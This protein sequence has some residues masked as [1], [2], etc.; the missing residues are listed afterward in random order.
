MTADTNP[1]AT[2]TLLIRNGKQM[3]A[4]FALAEGDKKVIGRDNSCQVQ[5]LDKGISRN[6]SLVEWKGDHF[7]LVDLGSTNG[8]FVNNK[9]IISRKLVDGDI[10]KIGQTELK[11]KELQPE[12]PAASA[13]FV[14]D[15]FV[16]KSP[17]TI[18]ERVDVNQSLA[19]SSR[20][21]HKQDGHEKEGEGDMAA[22]YLSTI[23][24]VSNLTN[25]EQDQAKL[26]AAIMDKIMEVFKPDRAFIVVPEGEDFRVLVQRDLQGGETKLSRT[27]LKKTIHEGVSVL[28]ANAMLDDRFSGNMSIVAQ[29][30]QSVISVPLESSKEVLGAIYID[31]V[32]LSNRFNKAHLDLLTAI[33][34]QAGVAA[35]RAILFKDYMEKE[36]MQ[37]ALDIARKIQT[38]LLPSGAPEN[39]EYDLVGWNVTC[40]ETGGDYYDFLDLG[41]G[42]WAIAIGDV[43]GH[44][45]GAA[46]LMATSRAF[47]KALAG[48]SATIPVMMNEL[49]RLLADD[50]GEDRFITMFYG[51]LDTKTMTVRYAN[52][53][54]DNPILYHRSSQE[55]EALESTGIPLGMI[56]EYDYDES[57]EVQI[58]PGEILVLS[59]DGITEAMDPAGQEFGSER[60]HAV[61]KASAGKS[62]NQIVCDC[63]DELQKFCQGRPWRDDLTLVVIKFDQRFPKTGTASY[64]YT[65]K[66]G[67]NKQG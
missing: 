21:Y 44:G 5:I 19:V 64:E 11:F 18:M 7:L 27:I 42:R 2:A 12:A 24:E 3:G 25:A 66:Y 50:M 41:Q 8:T 61:V 45:V 31:S 46:L 38:S 23:Y 10:L 26:F 65:T 40:D 47:V 57:R 28:S 17:N 6:H 49:N 67:Q 35:H 52:A 30:I 43:T 37:Q 14:K 51:E 20:I 58:R 32:A 29:N 16:E 62:A 60:L 59:T 63:H 53:G 34:K 56:K 39:F 1:K 22:V 36:R 55:F 48:K 54:H 9:I 33:G 13:S 4:S 15:D